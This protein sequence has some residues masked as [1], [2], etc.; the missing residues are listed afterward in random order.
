VVVNIGT[1]PVRG[2]LTKVISV[3][4]NDRTSPEVRLQC[5]AEIRSALVCEPNIVSLGSIKRN[6]PKIEKTVR[7]TRGAA[8]PIKPRVMTTTNPL[9]KA[10]LREIEAGSTYDLDIVAEPPWPNSFLRA[11]V[12]LDTG[13]TEV[14]MEIVMVS[15]ML[16]PRVQATP[17]RFYVRPDSSKGVRLAARLVWDDPP[18]KATGVV[19]NDPG[20]TARLEEEG[21]QQMVVLTAAAGYAVPPGK[22]IQVTVNTDD[23]A[24]PILQ[25]PVSPM[26]T[27]AA[28]PG[29]PAAGRAPQA[30]PPAGVRRAPA[31]IQGTPVQ[32]GASQRLK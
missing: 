31:T 12:Q 18:G 3:V 24:V 22:N 10:E 13:T 27:P 11:S 26:P 16:T 20:L 5:E 4:T 25:I 30:A 14:P 1:G 6:S 28:R 17:A 9:V 29:A 2:K 15:G 8:G 19:V 32:A 21:S 23:P 7:I